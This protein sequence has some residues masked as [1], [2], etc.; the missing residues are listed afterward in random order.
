[1]RERFP[2]VELAET[3]SKGFELP[4]ASR[5]V[6]RNN[7]LKSGPIRVPSAIAAATAGK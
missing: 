7:I 3:W 4:P 6:A 5:E 2:E 1:M